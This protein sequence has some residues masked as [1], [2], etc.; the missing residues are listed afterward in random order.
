MATP[1]N[2]PR[3][4]PVLISAPDA[5]QRPGPFPGSSMPTPLAKGS[6]DGRAA[7][8]CRP[9]LRPCW[10][11]GWQAGKPAAPPRN[12]PADALDMTV[13]VARQCVGRRTG[14][15]VRRGACGP[16]RWCAGSGWPGGRRTVQAVPVGAAGG[17]GS[18]AVSYKCTKRASGCRRS[19]LSPTVVSSWPA[20]SGPTPGQ[21]EQ[22]CCGPGDRR[23]R[24]ASASAISSFRRG[25]WRESC[26]SVT[27][28]AQAGSASS[29]TGR[30]RARMSISSPAADPRSFSRIVAGAVMTGARTPE[31]V[32]APLTGSCSQPRVTRPTRRRVG[33]GARTGPFGP[34]VMP[35]V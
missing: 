31:R 35:S 34:W 6:P 3:A 4:G 30:E 33:P 20:V 23:T 22:A 25:Q 32:Q 10:R 21:G 24:S 9:H 11:C 17:A 13:G 8:G 15:C 16:T 26:R 18:G 28:T 1:G 14:G 5:A 27:L 2:P 7:D 12:R 29:P 19:G